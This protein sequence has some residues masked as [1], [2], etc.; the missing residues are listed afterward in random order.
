MAAQALPSRAPR[1]VI[2]PDQ[3]LADAVR[4]TLA[5]AVAGMTYYEA[6][7][8][9]GE[10]EPLHQ[11]RVAA[12]RLRAIVQLFCGAIHGSRVRIYKRDLP[13]LGQAAGAVRECDVMEALIRDRGGRLDPALANA[14][15]PLCEALA[16]ARDAAHSRFVAELCTKRYTRMCE[17]LANPLL[18]RALPATVAG[19]DAPAMIAPIARSVRKAGKRIEREAP[20]EL[21]HR[22]RVRIKRLRYALEMLA[23]M[24]GKRSRRALIR[25]EQMQELL[26]VHQDMVSTIAWLRTY[27]ANAGAV[28]PETLMAVGAMLQALVMQREKLAARAGRRWR[29]IARS[30]L[31]DDVLEEIS[32][33]AEPHLEVVRQ[34]AAEAARIARIEAGEAASAA[35]TV[36][37]IENLAQGLPLAQKPSPGEA[38]A[39]A[40]DERPRAASGAANPVTADAGVTATPERVDAPLEPADVPPNTPIPTNG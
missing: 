15:T 19:C 12:R 3:P 9:A 11:M 1:A 21:F 20:P 18:R 6:A 16:A 27:A 32:R 30:G 37:A 8:M 36:S 24:G 33:A 17:R 34:A 40:P 38:S 7:A 29:K 39:R 5:T 10:I 23:E 22:L 4:R 2:A 25:L 26:G 35:A 28:A 31:L 13:W 14:L